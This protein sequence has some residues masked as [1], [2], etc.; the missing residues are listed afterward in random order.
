V[1]ILDKESLELTQ[2]IVKNISFPHPDTAKPY[3][4]S[5]VVDV[6]IEAGDKTATYTIPDSLQV[7]YAG[8]LVLATG[9]ELMSNELESMKANAQS[10][11][12]SVDRQNKIVKRS[13][14]ILAS[15]NP[16]YKEKAE[17][18]KRLTNLENS[19]NK[20]SELL[21]AFINKGGTTA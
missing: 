2:G 13:D 9:K 10:I 12:Q 8:N 6:T 11:L 3:G 15:L 1:H 17:N 7:T 20:M 19:V 4:Q 5:L 14:E 16:V 18:E 21:E